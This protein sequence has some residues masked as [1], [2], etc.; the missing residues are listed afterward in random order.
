VSA[1]QQMQVAQAFINEIQARTGRT[2]V[3]Y[4]YPSFWAGLGDT[5]QFASYPLWFANYQTSCPHV[6]S[7]WTN[8]QFWQFSSSGTV[9]GM[10]CP[11]ACDLDEFNGSL[12]DLQ[13][14]AQGSQASCGGSQSTCASDADCCSGLTCQN[15]TCQGPSCTAIWGA[16][17]APARTAAS[18]TGP[19]APAAG[20][21]AAARCARRA[22]CASASPRGSTARTM[23][24]AARD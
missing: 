12:A 9:P 6:P 8:W 1:A 10:N 14:F 18:E 21:A 16:C 17:T 3:I 24:I 11:G 19:A 7:P 13:A 23:S 20:S 2:T 15:S 4:T 22:A 5:S